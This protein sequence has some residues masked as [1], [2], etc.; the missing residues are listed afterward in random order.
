[1]PRNE[2][3]RFLAAG[4]VAGLA[5]NIFDGTLYTV[6][7]RA[8]AA[9]AMER[10]GIQEPGPVG[11]VLYVLLAFMIGFV[12]I[13]FYTGMRA[14]LGAGT[15]TALRTG[16]AVWA[17]AYFAP[18]LDLMLEGIYTTRMFVLAAGF[19]LITLPLATMAG[20]RVYRAEPV[21]EAVLAG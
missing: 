19:T 2:T 8:D 6:I 12:A 9:A 14:R 20:A 1:M 5:I 10:L 18:F 15:G 16:V 7:L 13:W 11:M 21:R 4:A 3:R 17:I